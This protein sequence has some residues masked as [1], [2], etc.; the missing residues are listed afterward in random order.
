M[1]DYA[2]DESALER[3]QTLATECIGFRAGS[4]LKP[5]S[6]DEWKALYTVDANFIAACSPA[7]VLSLLASLRASRKDEARPMIESAIVCEVVEWDVD[8]GKEVRITVDAEYAPFLAAGF[9]DGD[10]LILA[11]RA[12]S[13]SSEGVSNG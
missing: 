2:L 9:K 11:R 3:L 12:A 8:A 1:S 5:W 4:T 13:P 10:K 6:E 7:V